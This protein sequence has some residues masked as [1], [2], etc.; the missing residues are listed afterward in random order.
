[1]RKHFPLLMA[2]GAGIGLVTFF[3]RQI[4]R[5]NARQW[6]SLRAERRSQGGPGSAFI[7][8]ASSGIGESFARELAHRGYNLVLLARRE[9]RLHSLADLLQREYSVQVETLVADLNDPADLERAAIRVGEIPDLDLLVNN[10]GFGNGGFFT[11]IDPQEELAMIRV[12]VEASVRL[13]RAALPGMVERRFGGIIN[14]SSMAG[15]IAYAGSHTY[16]STKAYLNFFSESLSYELAG[17]GVRVQALCPGFTYT[18]FH[19]QIGRPNLPAFLWLK[20]E[21][22]VAESL[23]GLREGQVI[24]V[25]GMLYKILYASLQLPLVRPLAS[26]AQSQVMAFRLARAG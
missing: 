15:M 14:V 3:K 17:T 10:A 13:A 7:T 9:Q 5:R 21:D 25:P 2:L 23:S 6:A 4:Y 18:E 11:E 24:V 19:K 20:P 26:F 12:H 1:M 16:G 8:G 22:V